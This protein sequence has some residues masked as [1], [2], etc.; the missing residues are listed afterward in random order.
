MPRIKPQRATR[1]P[2][3]IPLVPPTPFQSK[4]PTTPP[5]IVGEATILSQH[6]TSIMYDMIFM[7]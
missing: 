1:P 6:N 5:M 4:K 7:L 3:K 2:N